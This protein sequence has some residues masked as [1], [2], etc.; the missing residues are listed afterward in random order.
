[1]T[2]VCRH[3]DMAYLWWM[4]TAFLPLPEQTL[5]KVMEKRE[6]ADLARTV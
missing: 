6:L 2:Y 4:L 3:S 5:A 1:M